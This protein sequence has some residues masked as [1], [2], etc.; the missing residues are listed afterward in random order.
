MK[1]GNPLLVCKTCSLFMKYQNICIFRL[2]E[3]TNIPA[4][5]MAM[6]LCVDLCMC[7]LEKYLHMF[8][9][10]KVQ[11]E[12]WEC[13]FRS[14]KCLHQTEYTIDSLTLF[15]NQ[16]N[17]LCVLIFNI[18]TCISVENSF[19]YFSMCM[20]SKA[21]YPPQLNRP[22]QTKLNIVHIWSIAFCSFSF[23]TETHIRTPWFI[24]GTCR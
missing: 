7:V 17:F 16:D 12:R 23:Y 15:S 24:H 11:R 10:R 13:M 18:I 5:A 21:F 8:G 4:M 9:E 2:L 6:S 3:I 20:I 19:I 1:F 22:L 14:W